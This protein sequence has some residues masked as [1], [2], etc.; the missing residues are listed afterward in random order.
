MMVVHT[1]ISALC[2]LEALTGENLVVSIMAAILAGGNA[3]AA[4]VQLEGAA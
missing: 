1:V 3:W 4:I 2:A